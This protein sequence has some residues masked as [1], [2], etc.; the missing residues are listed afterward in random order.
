MNSVVTSAEVTPPATLESGRRLALPRWL[1]LIL[2]NRKGAIGFALLLVMV[3]MAI[4]AP[5]I[6]RYDPQA[7]ISLPT[8]PPSAAHPFGTNHQGQDVFSQIVYGARYTLF[9]GFATGTT[10]ILMCIVVG[11]TAGYVGGWVDDVLSL[12]MNVF[13]LIPPLPLMI[14]LSGYLQSRNVGLIIFVITFTSWAYGARVLRAQTLS[15]RGKDFVQAAVVGGEKTWRIIF[16]EILPNMISLIVSSYIGAI[17]LA[18]LADVGL[19]FL[20]FGDVKATSWGMTLYWAQQ[21]SALLS[22]EWWDFIFAGVAIA[23]TGTACILINFGIDEISNPRLRRV[24]A[25]RPRAGATS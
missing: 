18:I 5:L 3:L 21:Y 9:I 24:K 11:M 6:A 1:G 2:G 20:G 4:F 15:I 16:R 22:G 23:L 14:V 25:P 17:L 13:L 10:I 7:M 19:E 8:Q 12:I